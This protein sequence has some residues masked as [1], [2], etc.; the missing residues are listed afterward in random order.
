GALGVRDFYVSKDGP[1]LG[2]REAWASHVTYDAQPAHAAISLE[3]A[4]RRLREELYRIHRPTLVLHG[5]RDRVCP[6]ENAWKVAERLGTRDVRVVVYP[7]SHH[8]L[9]RDVEREAVR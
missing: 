7:R 1:D 4:G 8:I 3:R 6:V 5:A 9:P 2:D